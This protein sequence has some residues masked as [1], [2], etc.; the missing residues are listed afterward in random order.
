MRKTLAPLAVAV[1]AAALSF[2][3]APPARAQQLGAATL[4]GVVKDPVGAAVPGVK[5]LATNV[6][7]GASRETQTNDE[8]AYSLSNMQP[9][10]Y[11]MRFEAQ[12]FKVITSASPVKLGVGQS[13]T[14]DIDLEVKGVGEYVDLLGVVPLVDNTSSKVDQLIDSGEILNLPLNGRNFL[15]LALLTPG[16]APA[17]NFDPTKTNTIVI[18]SAGQFGRGGSGTVGGVDTDD[19]GV[20]GGRQHV[21]QDAVAEFQIA[22]NRFDASIGR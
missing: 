6:A 19:D 21:S 14:M 8:G 5:V 1:F 17:P 11:E 16:N 15:E 10:D 7:T 22:T 20:G 2:A 3:A 18:S 4:R 9:G 13:V 12:G